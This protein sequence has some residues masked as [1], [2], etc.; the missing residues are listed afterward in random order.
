[1]KIDDEKFDEKLMKN[2]KE[3]R[4]LVSFNVSMS[5][6]PDFFIFYFF[7]LQFISDSSALNVFY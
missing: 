5:L 6:L 3:L 2:L 1:M 7:T 4:T